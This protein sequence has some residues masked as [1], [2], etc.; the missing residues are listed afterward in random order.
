MQRQRVK[1]VLRPLHEHLYNFLSRRKWLV[2]G[3]VTP[4]IVR[5]LLSQRSPGED[6]ISGDYEAAT[7]N[8]YVDVVKCI[9]DVLC[10]SPSL[11]HEE[12]EILSGSFAPENLF[13]VSASGKEHQ[14]RRG[15]MMGNLM[16][17]NILCL[18]NK[19]C[20]DIVS[21]L[22]RRRGDLPRKS[23][24][25]PLINGDDI[26]FTGDRRAFDDWVSVTSHYG[27]VV[28]EKK[29][30]VSPIWLEL[31]SR[32]FLCS[33]GRVR[34]LRK[35]VLSALQPGDSPDCLLTR[36]WD[37]FRTLSPSTFRMACLTL[38]HQIAKRGVSLSSIPARLRRVLLKESWFRSALFLEPVLEKHGTK[39][40]VEIVSKDVRPSEEAM[41]VYEDL[42][43][44]DLRLLFERY[45]GVEV[46][47]YQEK[48][49]K[50]SPVIRRLMPGRIR[51]STRWIWRWPKR[52]YEYFDTHALP[53]RH[54]SAKIWEDDHPH[55]A[56]RVEPV[57][58]HA[59]YPPP[60]ALLQAVQVDQF[61]LWPNGS[62]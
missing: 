9:A 60:A 52:V 10:E 41:D 24:R 25:Y 48:I 17:F 13:W 54:L 27:L 55:L 18:L 47:P 57:Y 29:T 7:N 2:R 20:F 56:V 16:S 32:S 59:G 19:A 22:R 14:I 33:S 40:S 15:S 62:V 45:R 51:Y 37:G 26:A 39:R 34:A 53:M 50:G 38:R 1:A 46:C 28:N 12:R 49:S 44:E 11:T 30:G 58:S 5:G 42:C 4:E 61:V 23:Y 36:L 43:K 3:D 8:I 35:P 31:N 21:S 6:I